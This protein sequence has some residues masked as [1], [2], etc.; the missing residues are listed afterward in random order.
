MDESKKFHNGFTLIELS[1]VLVIIG[2]IV[3]GVLVGQ[4]LIK[5]AAVRATISQIEK[6]NTAVNTFRGK[7][8]ALPGDMNS[9]TALQF[10]FAARGQYTG[11]G[12][13][14]GVIQGIT[15][16]AA[17]SYNGLT[18]SAG[19]TAV[20]WVDLSAAGLID[21]SFNTASETILPASTVAGTG[22]DL[23]FPQAKIG[24][25]NYV[26]VW[27]ADVF[28]PGDGNPGQNGTTNYFGISAITQ[29][30]T[31]N[32]YSLPALTVQE[33]YNIDKKMDDGFP[34]T[35]RVIAAYED[36][37]WFASPASALSGGWA[38][39]PWTQGTAQTATSASAATC[40][41]NGNNANGQLQYSLSQSAGAMVN[42]ALS[43]QFQ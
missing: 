39:D 16:D 14:N 40:Y 36:L 25:G 8:A 5:A 22:V 7:F 6:Y 31:Y 17:S 37:Q 13:G 1:I 35:G 41:D 30:V 3:G 18:A 32:M 4:D 20:F 34:S 27:S 24:R 15:A 26:Y 11:E 12:D 9:A 29:L 33:A 38:N 21:G 28:T 23:Y 43:F 10:G 19:E 42:C 2:L